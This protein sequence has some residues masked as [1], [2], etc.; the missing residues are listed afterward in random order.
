MTR[1]D[2]FSPLTPAHLEAII[3]RHG[4]RRVA[5]ALLRA[6]LRGQGA[7]PLA[8]RFCP[9]DDHMRRDIGLPPR[10]PSPPLPDWLKF[11]W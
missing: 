2:P 5:L 7:R 4:L 3:A 1:T 6:A 11:M 10:G 8:A 9:L